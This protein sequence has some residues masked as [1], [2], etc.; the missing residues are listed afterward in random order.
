MG[1]YKYDRVDDDLKY[2]KSLHQICRK[3]S[4]E[5]SCKVS[6]LSHGWFSQEGALK[7]EK[8]YRHV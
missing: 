5:H 7:L 1:Q 4:K 6:R 3:W 2:Q 8:S